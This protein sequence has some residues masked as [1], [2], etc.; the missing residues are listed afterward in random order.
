MG[1]K[2]LHE[3]FESERIYIY[4][5]NFSKNKFCCTHG[6]YI[7]DS[8]YGLICFVFIKQTKVKKTKS[9]SHFRVP[10]CGSKTLPTHH[11]GILSINGLKR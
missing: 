10:V 1:R 11:A 5:I 9:F 2:I 4:I 3:R 7:H 6:A 8:F